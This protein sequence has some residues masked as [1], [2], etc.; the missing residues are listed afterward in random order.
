ME[1]ASRRGVPLG[2]RVVR[3]LRKI[4]PSTWI[5]GG[6]RAPRGGEPGL[7]VESTA[8]WR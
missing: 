6:D 2:P 4:G 8:V 3:D 5:R 7:T 1:A